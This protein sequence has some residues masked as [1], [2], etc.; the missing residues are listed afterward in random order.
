MEV[1]S[2]LI[3]FI[4]ALV[5]LV[6]L[7]YISPVLSAL[8]MILVPL[9]FVYLMPD[10][11][12]EFL[13]RMQFS[14]VVPVYNIHILLLIWSAFIGVIA[15]AEV[16]SWYLLRET[17]PKKQRKQAAVSASAEPGVLTESARN[18]N[19]GVLPRFVEIMS[20]KK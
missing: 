9:A 13:S 6:T 16:L 14:F 17:G 18:R 15:Y 2:F 10:Q 11:A 5:L 20:G 3:F 12:M 19:K 1:L 7:I 8:L 4:Y